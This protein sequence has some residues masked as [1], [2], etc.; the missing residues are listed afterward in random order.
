MHSRI[1]NFA[2][3]ACASLVS[4]GALA[5]APSDAIK[6]GTTTAT[7]LEPAY[8]VMYSAATTKNGDLVAVKVFGTF[9]KV[10]DFGT[11]SMVSE[12]QFDCKANQFSYAKV[13][14]YEG[15]NLTGKGQ[16]LP[17]NLLKEFQ[18]NAVDKADPTMSVGA[19]PFSMIS[20]LK[21][22]V[23]GAT[24]GA[25][26]SAE[27]N[28]AALAIKPAAALSQ[29]C[30]VGVKSKFFWAADKKWYDGTVI[31]TKPDT[32]RVHYEGYGNEDDAW[33]TP[34]NMRLLVL[35]QDG[36]KYPARVLNKQSQGK[37]L[38]KYEGYDD[39]SNEVV[40][41]SQLSIRPSR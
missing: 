33:V 41:L 19:L 13:T 22:A 37:Y 38:V 15:P 18:K 34:E 3:I 1:L 16:D 26:S 12:I 36:K 11:R 9:A 14:V 24:S 25:T 31:D 7:Q 20:K 5:Q 39:A 23:C 4:F 27:S 6:L 8:D 35:W 17:L 28:P 2:L 40:D 10:D 21:N 32:C 29:L 30:T